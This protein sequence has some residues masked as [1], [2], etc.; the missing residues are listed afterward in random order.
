MRILLKNKLTIKYS[1]ILLILIFILLSYWVLKSIINKYYFEKL[2]N[3]VEICVEYNQIKYLC[4]RE[5]YPLEDFLER[6]KAI[7]VSSV[8]I[9]EETFLTLQAD[10]KINYFSS[11]DISKL[12]LCDLISSRS[13]ITPETI[14][15]R[16]RKLAKNLISILKEKTKLDIKSISI[17]NYAIIN[18][19][20]IPY[21]KQVGWGFDTDKIN[22][23]TKHKLDIIMRFY[24]DGIS[25][26]QTGFQ[27]NLSAI[28][29]NKYIDEK[30]IETIRYN[31]IKI[32]VFEFWSIE[33]SERMLLNKNINTL[34]RT[35]RIDVNYM[36]RPIYILIQRWLRSVKE[37]NCRLLY[38]DFIETYNLETNLNYLRK[39]CLDLKNNS[40]FLRTV[41]IK[42]LPFQ[43]LSKVPVT[44][45]KIISF[46]ISI[47]I[48]V[49]SILF[50]IKLNNRDRKNNLIHTLKCF[51]VMTGINLYAA[52]SIVALLSHY[53]FIV[54]IDRFNG[55]KLSLFLP[56]VFIIPFI[57][58]LNDIKI[59]LK[60]TVQIKDILIVS[61]IIIIIAIMVI[62]SDYQILQI[63]G[64]EIKIRSILEKIFIYRP[65]FKEFLIG[66]P[67]L[68]LGL[69]RKNR[70][71]IYLGLIGQVS[72]IN[73]FL[74]IHTPIYVSVIRTFCGIL[75]GLLLGVLLIYILEYTKKNNK[76]YNLYTSLSKC[77]YGEQ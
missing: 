58:N 27:N 62:R 25:W 29:S 33:N 47:I 59:F 51:F 77:F 20:N 55:T 5:R 34:I 65:R 28:I 11:N 12:S 57:C 19:K 36:D 30:Y 6:I 22:L 64:I 73:T 70:F 52:F 37:R 16:D 7:G 41:I 72:L 45:T 9:D 44:L 56:F 40:Y 60:K 18:I 68:M 17:D 54:G 21:L 48:P 74:H 61:I 50:I 4:E 63:N 39:L 31:N 15:I 1:K 2:N 8:V 10:N 46:I 71:F 53:S 35:H 66:Y 32:P 76:I 75:I 23:I 24:K 49:F 26:M 3:T 69:Y 14:I 13:Y 43:F 42:T 67:L 38:F